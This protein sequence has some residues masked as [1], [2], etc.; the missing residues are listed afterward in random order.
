MLVRRGCCHQ[1]KI[2]RGIFREK[3]RV[4]GQ[5]QQR[6]DRKCIRLLHNFPCSLVRLGVH[7]GHV[8]RV[9]GRERN[10]KDK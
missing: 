3:A 8:G 5:R 7:R 1:I 10:N 6:G 9:K 4:V 2:L